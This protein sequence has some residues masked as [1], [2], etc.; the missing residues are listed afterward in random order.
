MRASRSRFV[1]LVRL[2]RNWNTGELDGIKVFYYDKICFR[3]DQNS[4]RRFIPKRN[5][6]GLKKFNVFVYFGEIL[7]L[8]LL[9]AAERL[10]KKIKKKQC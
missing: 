7:L 10:K 6:N 4:I 2:F 3:N 9:C 8:S 5:P 1:F